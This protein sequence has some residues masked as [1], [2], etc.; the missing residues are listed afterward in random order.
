MVVVFCSSAMVTCL[1]NQL[2]VPPHNTTTSDSLSLP[3]VSVSESF[4]ETIQL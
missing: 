2:V 3:R 1:D 4:G